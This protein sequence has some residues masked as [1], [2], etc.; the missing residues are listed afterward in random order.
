MP[1]QV[2]DDGGHGVP[3]GQSDKQD[4]ERAMRLTE[5]VEPECIG[6]DDVRDRQDAQEERRYARGSGGGGQIAKERNGDEQHV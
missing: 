2:V 1:V 6:A 4:R 3:E 5:N